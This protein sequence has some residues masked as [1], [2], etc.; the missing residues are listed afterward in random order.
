[1]SRKSCGCT[2]QTCGCCEGTEILTP[3]STVNRPGLDALSYRVGTHGTFFETMKARL[4]SIVVE[5]SVP[6]GQTSQMLRPLRGLTTRDPSDPAIALLD[7]WAAVADVL[8][9]YQ[10]RIANEGYLRT[11]T[12][13]RSVLELARLVG[14]ALRPGVAATVFLAY[15]LDNTQLVPVE[16][17]AGARSQSI[18]GPGELPQSFE[19]SDAL[20]ARQEWN[21]LQVR[22]TKPQDI[23]FDD[24]LKVDRLYLAGTSTNLK[25]GD[26]LLLVFEGDA[27]VVRNVATVDAQFD[28]QRTLI[29]FHPVALDVL[30]A[31][32]VFVQAIQTSSNSL[33]GGLGAQIAPSVIREAQ[34]FIVQIHLGVSPAPSWGDALFGAGAGRF[35][36]WQAALDTLNSVLAPESP[37]PEGGGGSQPGPVT[38]PSKFIISLLRPPIAQF[39]SS[40]QLTR[41]L[42]TA[43]QLQA[44]TQPQLLVKFAPQLKD[45]F[46]TAWAN[47]TV[48][49][50]ERAL[51][52]VYAFRIEASL[53]G[54]NVPKMATYDTQNRLNQ[55]SEWSEWPLANDE[56]PATMFLDQA[57]DAIQT[58]SV[59]ML[60]QGTG[61]ELTREV[62]PAVSVQTEQRTEYGIS[63]RTTEITF[64]QN[65]RDD[66]EGD[67]LGVLRSVL[68]HA[69]SEELTLSEEPIESE[70][71]GH[72]TTLDGLYEGLTSGRWII[73]SGERA[74][75]EGVS[76]VSGTELLMVSALKQTFDPEL[77][78]D[79]THTTLVL[80]TPM[81]YSYQRN[82]KLRIYGNVVKATHGETKNEPLGSGDGTQTFQS[83]TLKQPP[84][85]FVA[86]SNPTG[87]DSTLQI[88]VNDVQWHE[89]DTLAGMGPTDRIFVAK[90]D[91]KDNTTAIFGNGLQGARLPT[92]VQNINSIYRSGIGSA[93]NVEAEQISMLF[94][95]PLGVKS[96]INPLRASGG[97]DREDID[98]ARGNAPLA[99]MSLDRLVSLQDYA[100]FS[101]TF[102]GIGKA[103]SRRLSDG[104]RELV[105]IT[106]AGVDDAP[107][108]PT[109]DLY[110]NL[111]L[112][113]RRFGDPDLPVQ[114]DLRE[115]LVLVL[116][117]K[118]KLLPDY[119]WDP[120]AQTIRDTILDSFGFN[121]RFLGQPVML[122]EVI[123]A[124]QNTEGVSYLD[125]DGFGGIPEKVAHPDGT[126]SLLTFEQMADAVA[127]ITE[128]ASTEGGTGPVQRVDANQADF[129]NGAVRPAQLAIFTEA[130]QDTIVLN[131]IL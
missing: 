127:G 35:N 21:N 72:E 16:I 28:A 81:A 30:E 31:L 8:T 93:G 113:L 84:L 52:T 55:P 25:T 6:D 85:T 48:S 124:I 39:G 62:L 106:I 103:S 77:A 66:E 44:D 23:T 20:D 38:A 76:G 75:I 36:D 19:T 18:P 115:L 51:K 68:V 49:S 90:T 56:S 64:A 112:A 104:R 97:A 116:S 59:V 71:G 99:V 114:V 41:T 98:Q 22:L 89:V 80:A 82:S 1:M 60:Q 11:A 117:A 4:A 118:V 50:A 95:R 10:E 101:R 14:Y 73:I 83:F 92:G 63:G 131:Q 100:D 87:V 57:H 91:D 111:V 27:K 3:V 96:V 109:S 2:I 7:G 33:A 34:R 102:A 67:D 121:K 37:A 126:R 40:L 88:F 9:F 53:F 78:G 119:L 24:A 120:V 129:E 79:K 122:S 130:V 128:I 13:R 17:P 47:A 94:T 69:Q 105:E 110:K 45:T 123:S 54:A 74:D 65:W 29:T 46:Y 5:T 26:L 125:V 42:P 58:G 107:I 70:V 43:F 108:D 15:T 12:E 86:A 61:N 32:Q